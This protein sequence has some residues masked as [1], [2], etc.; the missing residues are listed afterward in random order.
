MTKEEQIDILIDA[1][2]ALIEIEEN[3][4]AV[5]RGLEALSIDMADSDHA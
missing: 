4:K 2:T 3:A 1:M 5:R